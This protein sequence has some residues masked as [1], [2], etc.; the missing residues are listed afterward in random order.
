[1]SIFNLITGAQLSN[2]AASPQTKVDVSVGSFDSPAGEIT[3]TSVFTKDISAAWTAGSGNGGLFSGTVAANTVYHVFFIHSS[4]TGASDYG[5]DTSVTA[6]NT[7][8]SGALQGTYRRIGSVLTDASGHIRAFHQHG[9]E[10]W[11]DTPI[12]DVDVTNPG[13][14]AVTRTLT[15]PT[16]VQVAAIVNAVAYDST[17]DT[18][19][20][21]SALEAADVAPAYASAVDLA[22]SDKTVE[23]VSQNRVWTNTSA[24]VRTRLSFSSAS[25]AFKMLTLGWVDTRGK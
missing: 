4:Q 24:Q 18:T 17:G 7:P 13:T 20:Y 19:H 16:G 8:Y 5:F 2:N 6:A 23:G 3:N 25:T 10:F 22:G 9:D 15:V 14:S 11:L 1:M 12:K 21:I